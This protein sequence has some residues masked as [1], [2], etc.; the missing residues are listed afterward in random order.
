M[1]RWAEFRENNYDWYFDDSKALVID[2]AR[3]IDIDSEQDFS[4]VKRLCENPKNMAGFWKQTVLPIR[5][6]QASDLF[7]PILVN[8]VIK[9]KAV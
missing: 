3:S 9:T 4:Q 6:D 5:T 7:F 1:A 8:I 2:R